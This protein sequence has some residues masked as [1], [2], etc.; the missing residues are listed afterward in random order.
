MNRLTLSICLALVIL[1]SA[2]STATPTPPPTAA[3]PTPIPPT[4]PN[5]AALSFIEID[6]RGYYFRTASGEPFIPI[7]FNEHQNLLDQ[8]KYPPE[9]LDHYFAELEAHGVNTVRL[10][11]SSDRLGV[12]S[13]LSDVGRC[14]ATPCSERTAARLAV[15]AEIAAAHGVRLMLSAH[16]GELF[17]EDTW[18]AYPYNAANGGPCANRFEML[19]RDDPCGQRVVDD[20]TAMVDAI[21]GSPVVMAWDL[22]NEIDNFIAYGVGM[23]PVQRAQALQRWINE[24]P[25][26][27]ETYEPDRYGRARLTTVSLSKPERIV[28]NGIDYWDNSA[29]DFPSAHSYL[30]EIRLPN[31]PEEAAEFMRTYTLA[32]IA[33]MS[34]RRPYLDTEIPNCRDLSTPDKFCTDQ[35]FLAV[36]HAVGW[37]A[38][39][40]GAAG[41]G[42]RFAR[43]P[44][45]WGWTDPVTGVTYPQLGAVSQ[46][47]LDDYLAMSR[48]VALVDWT[49]LPAEDF[50]SHYAAGGHIVMGVGDASFAIGWIMRDRRSSLPPPDRLDLT[51]LPAAPFVVTWVDDTTGDVIGSVT[52]MGP[53]ASVPLP[54][55]STSIAFILEVGAD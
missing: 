11:L 36:H 37:S 41:S 21:A 31:S 15:L 14:G 10:F 45:A 4:A 32:N 7:G 28:T 1:L 13:W 42:L 23:T 20:I 33:A 49:R 3:R 27:I 29:F 47:M 40:S 53:D 25:G 6:P 16:A 19:D 12:N 26:L 8:D 24:A 48:F 54:E 18:A 2:C 9:V 22:M 52:V 17:K 39:M 34:V 35:D 50:T 44:T 46:A 30:P 51:G 5:A 43:Q 38:L 55:F